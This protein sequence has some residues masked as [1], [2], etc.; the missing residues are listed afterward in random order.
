MYNI[1][2]IGSLVVIFL[3]SFWIWLVWYDEGDLGLFSY[4]LVPFELQHWQ[5]TKIPVLL[6]LL[7][8]GVL[9]GTIYL[10]SKQH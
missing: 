9:L 10:S 2:I 1:L 5:K 3:C 6:R 7:A 8:Y 4:L